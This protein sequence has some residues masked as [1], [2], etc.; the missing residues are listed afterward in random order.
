ML[1]SGQIKPSNAANVV[2]VEHYCP[3]ILDFRSAERRISALENEVLE[4]DYL[5]YLI[6]LIE[7]QS[8]SDLQQNLI[9][10]IAGYLVRSMRQI[11]FVM[12]VSIF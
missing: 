12:I 8:I 2:N 7:R 9:Y 4:G 10:Y 3:T 11:L 5:K 6:S 1:L